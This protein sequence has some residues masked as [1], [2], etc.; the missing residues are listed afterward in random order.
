MADHQRR[1]PPRGGGITT[2]TVPPTTPVVAPGQSISGKGSPVWVHY[3]PALLHATPAIHFTPSKV[4]AFA[5]AYV[6]H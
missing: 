5:R 6:E 1:D 4:A 2:A 3:N